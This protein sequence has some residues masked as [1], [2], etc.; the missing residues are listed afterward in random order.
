MSVPL[1][2]ADLPRGLSGGSDTWDNGLAGA[3]L[4]ADYFDE[5]GTDPEPEPSDAKALVFLLRRRRR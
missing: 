1:P 4:L 2:Q 5:P 3:I